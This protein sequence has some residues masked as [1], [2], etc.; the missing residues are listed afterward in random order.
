MYTRFPG[1]WNW[2][3]D[4]TILRLA[5]FPFHLLRVFGF[6]VCTR[7]E[8]IRII[9]MDDHFGDMIWSASDLL[10]SACFL[11]VFSHLLSLW[12]ERNIIKNISR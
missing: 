8:A 5:R 11:L 7:R 10:C 1:L 6:V 4:L 12:G 2:I 3:H 9:P